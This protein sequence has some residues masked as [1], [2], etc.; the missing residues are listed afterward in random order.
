MS[1]LINI[2]FFN[3]IIPFDEVVNWIEYLKK[4]GNIS[5]FGYFFRSIGNINSYDNF[6]NQCECVKNHS[7]ILFAL[8]GERNKTL[9]LDLAFIACRVNYRWCIELKSRTAQIKL[10]T[11]YITFL[12][13]FLY[14]CH[15]FASYWNL[16]FIIPFWDT[17]QFH[18][19]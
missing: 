5:W 3:T 10:L 17:W 16:K 6:T 4:T 12:Q 9:G 19:V 18:V 8:R 11:F 13:N 7:N 1:T 15:L 2:I 14:I